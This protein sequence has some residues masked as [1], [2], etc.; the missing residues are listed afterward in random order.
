MQSDI[1]SDQAYSGD[2]LSF[3]KYADVFS[4]RISLYALFSG[5]D[6]KEVEA[7][8]QLTVMAK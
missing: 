8:M 6:A 2:D 3:V 7:L 1:L 4:D 5:N